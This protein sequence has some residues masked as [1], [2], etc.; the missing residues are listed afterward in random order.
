MKTTF[1]VGGW[2][3]SRAPVPLVAAFFV[4]LAS[5]ALLLRPR[6]PSGRPGPHALA[7]AV[8]AAGFLVLAVGN[9]RLFGGWGG[10]GGW[11][12]WNWLPWLAVAADDLLEYRTP[13]G[14]TW[15]LS[16]LVAFV[17][18]ANAAFAVRAFRLYG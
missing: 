6:S 18:V 3:F 14:R 11:Y 17:L 12:A 8:A 16:A 1:W 9:R 13:R 5:A 4:L 2:S 10:L 7:L 15:L